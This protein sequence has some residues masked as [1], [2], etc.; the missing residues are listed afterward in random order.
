MYSSS[1]YM[2]WEK[3]MYWVN[4]NHVVSENRHV[5]YDSQEHHVS[6]E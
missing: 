6:L 5:F 4:V 3:Y 1:K 2:Y